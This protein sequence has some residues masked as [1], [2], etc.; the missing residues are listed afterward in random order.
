MRSNWSVWPDLLRCHSMGG[1]ELSKV[2]LWL[3]PLACA[4][5]F[6]WMILVMDSTHFF[7]ALPGRGHREED[8]HSEKR[9]RE[10]KYTKE[11]EK[12]KK[13][14]KLEENRIEETR[15][16]E[17]KRRKYKTKREDMQREEKRKSLPRFIH[18][19]L[20]PMQ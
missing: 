19:Y 9:R 15:K 4:C 7:M 18:T 1:G 13:Y 10:K 11:E 8:C 2:M 17:K 3:G 12:R 5:F 20:A 16:E 6:L 14:T